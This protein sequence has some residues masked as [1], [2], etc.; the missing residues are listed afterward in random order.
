MKEHR[1]H[2]DHISLLSSFQNKES[3]LKMF[4]FI[5]SVKALTILLAISCVHRVAYTP[6]AFLGF[7]CAKPDELCAQLSVPILCTCITVQ[8]EE[9]VVVFVLPV[10]QVYK[11]IMRQA[12]D[13][14]TFLMTVDGVLD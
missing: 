6:A 5:H 3:R 7:I 8:K 1:Q 9:K 12:L 14:V 4:V 2:G 10:V 13:I 11:R